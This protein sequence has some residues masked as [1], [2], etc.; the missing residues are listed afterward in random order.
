M[1]SSS[2]FFA[3][4]SLLCA[5]VNDVVFKRYAT[6]DR[7]RGVY[8]FGIGLVWAF[9]QLAYGG[10]RGFDVV[11]S[12]TTLVYGFGAGVLLALSNILLLESLTHID[13]SLG[14]TVYRLNTVGVVAFSVW[15][16]GESLGW[17][18]GL[19]VAVGVGAVATLYRPGG[20]GEATGRRFKLFFVMVVAAA[21]LRAAYG[22]VSKAGLNAGAS[23]QQ[24]LI[25]AAGCWVIFGIAYALQREKRF[26]I[27]GK[28][29]VY[30]SLSGVLVFLIVNFLLLAIEQGQA[31]VAIPVANMSFVIALLLSAGLGMERLTRRKFAAVA[32]AICSILLLSRV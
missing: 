4:L 5:G 14:S 12:E 8:V 11:L 21:I 31:S 2:V 1:I 32:M 28:K 25:L 26:R 20:Q 29:A 18:K 17:M 13:A 22:V 27:T 7:S 10:L 6:K 30:A 19:G 9:L 16:L 23:L 24:L 3:L 15:F